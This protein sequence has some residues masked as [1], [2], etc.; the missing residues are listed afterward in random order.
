MQNT[1]CKT[2][3]CHKS[4]IINQSKHTYRNTNANDTYIFDTVISEQ[5]LYIVLGYS[6]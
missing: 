4:I 6:V 2:K 5:T 1:A 3:Y